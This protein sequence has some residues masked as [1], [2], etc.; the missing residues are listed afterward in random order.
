MHRPPSPS[1]R[2]T[3]IRKAVA[4]I[5]KAG[6][7]REVEWDHS[8]CLPTRF[9]AHGLILD[10]CLGGLINILMLATRSHPSCISM[11]FADSEGGLGESL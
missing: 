5:E 3:K 6:M 1:R 2:R 8:R 10:D 7:V 11:D 4:F 9:A